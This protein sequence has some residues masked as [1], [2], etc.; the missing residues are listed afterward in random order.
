MGVQGSE[1]TAWL[2]MSLCVLEYWQSQG[3]YD[4]V[5]SQLGGLR[6]KCGLAAWS[7]H[8]SASIVK[9]C[10]ACLSAFD[11]HRRS[12]AAKYQD[13]DVSNNQVTKS[14]EELE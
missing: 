5:L 13:R 1:S 12:L 7:T 10:H 8:R 4:E 9:L 14:F 11:H 6:G 2:N 3:I